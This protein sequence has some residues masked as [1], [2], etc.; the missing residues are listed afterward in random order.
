MRVCVVKVGGLGDTVSVGPLVA[1]LVEAGLEVVVLGGPAAEIL[2]AHRM[3]TVPRGRLSGVWGL[4]SVLG[5]ARRVGRCDVAL[6]SP[7]ECT[8]AH[9]VAARIA[10]RRIGFAAGIARGEC[11]LTERLPLEADQSVY[12]TALSLGRHLLD[13]EVPLRR[14]AP[15]V[16]WA[17]GYDVL[18]AG[19]ATALQR[20]PGFDALRGD[21]RRVEEGLSLRELV[22]A[23]AG[24]GVFVGCHSGPLHLA[25]ALGVPFVAVAGPSA[26]AWDPP[27][28]DVPGRILRAGLPCQPCGRFGAPARRCVHGAGPPCLTALPPEAVLEAVE[29]V[30]RAAA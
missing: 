4:R 13:Q 17:G 2:P 6:L 16:R 28:H 5:L 24:A 21:W 15:A 10:P 1:A 30:R 14:W 11:F 27:W 8:A 22:H 9:A 18:H 29:E 7:D 3:V 25:T 23:I 20:W 19:A 26:R 12:R